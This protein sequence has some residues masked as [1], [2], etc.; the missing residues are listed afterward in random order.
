VAPE[1]QPHRVSIARALKEHGVSW[2]VGAEVTGWPLMMRFTRYGMGLAV[3]NDF[4][5]VPDGLAGIPI[6]N[7]PTFQYDAAIRADTPHKGAQWLLDLLLS[8][9]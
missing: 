6:R 8:Y 1:Q 3:I 7:F 5:P 2:Q 9:D 4:V